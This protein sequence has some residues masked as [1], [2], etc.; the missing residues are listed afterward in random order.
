MIRNL[1]FVT[2][3]VLCSS[4]APATEEK[5]TRT[6][7]Y[8]DLIGLLNNQVDYLASQNAVLEK[9]VGAGDESEILEITPD[10]KGWK[11]ELKLF[12]NAD[13]NKLGLTDAYDVEQLSRI[14]GGRK[15]IN[16]ARS[17]N[18]PIRLIE[19]NFSEKML[20]SLRILVEEKNEVYTFKK[21]MR[22]TFTQINDQTVLSQYSIVGTQAMVMKSD[23]DFSLNG[24]IVLNP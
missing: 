15:L 13:I 4:C 8:Y 16:A 11:E 1:L 18:Q 17:E 14:D 24:K 22:M 5:V 3:V 19:Y 2:I 20:E 7:V 9:K 10:D 23:L 12:F 21:E 6:N